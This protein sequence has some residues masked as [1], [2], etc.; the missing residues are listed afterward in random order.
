MKTNAKTQEKQRSQATG[1]P[2]SRRRNAGPRVRRGGRSRFRWLWSLI[3]AVACLLLI[4][5]GLHLVMSTQTPLAI[6]QATVPVESGASAPDLRL[7]LAQ[8]GA[9]DLAQQRGHLLLL[10]FLQTQPDTVANTSRDQAVVLVS[11]SQQ[12]NSRGVE[13]A[14]VDASALVSGTPASASALVNVVYDWNLGAVQL[15][16]DDALMASRLYGIQKL[17][18]TFLI[19]AAGVV[20]Q[21]WD[22][23]VSSSQAA[24]AVQALIVKA[25]SQ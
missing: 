13:V 1:R 6:S 20:R 2:V 9:F 18:T 19:D 21:R 10:S 14:I 7:S 11:M 23:F 4:G 12:Y 22:G 24:S 17:P 3:I 16:R 8:G 25:S 5:L 15:L